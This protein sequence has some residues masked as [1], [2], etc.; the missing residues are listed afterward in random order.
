MLAVV[1]CTPA[2]PPMPPEG[3]PVG[4]AAHLEAVVLERCLHCHTYDEPEAQLVLERGEGRDRMVD[5]PS[6]QVPQARLVVAG[7]LEASYLWLKVDHRASVGQGM[8][9][10]FVGSKRLPDAEVERF[11]RWIEDGALP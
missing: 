1:G 11:R 6:T 3:E 5:V 10:I 8:P 7:D 9:R 4:Y 2:Y